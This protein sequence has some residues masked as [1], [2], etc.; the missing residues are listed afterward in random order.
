MPGKDGITYLLNTTAAGIKPPLT[1]DYAKET[2][3]Q[4]GTES[5]PDALRKLLPN[6]T[7]D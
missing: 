5:L 1:D 3:R 6:T 4:I 2:L 7:P